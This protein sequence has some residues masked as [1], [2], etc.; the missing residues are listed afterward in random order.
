MSI[1]KLH[2]RFERIERAYFAA[3]AGRDPETVPPSIW[4]PAIFAAVPDT[5]VE[6]I[7][8]M[9]RWRARKA[10]RKWMLQ[11]NTT[12]ASHLADKLERELPGA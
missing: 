10:K 2:E 5:N 4:R 9:F 7:T 1:I 12:L 11:A 8:E 3:L 6:E